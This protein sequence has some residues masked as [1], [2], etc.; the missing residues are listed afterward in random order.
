MPVF[1]VVLLLVFGA[2]WSWQ[3]PGWVRGALTPEEVDYHIGMLEQN[4][5]MPGAEKAELLARLRAWAMADDGKPFFMLNLMRYYPQL[6]RFEGAPAFTGSPL[7]SNEHYETAVAPLALGRGAY[8][9]YAGMTHGQNLVEHA[10]ELD[11]WSRVI[12]M[13][14]PS[15]RAALELFADP[16]YAPVEPFKM[17]ALQVLLLPNHADLVIP[18][19][20]WLLGGVLLFL[21]MA[22]GWWRAARRR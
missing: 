9:L 1:A 11:H 20:R 7:E 5:V 16:D 17:M 4:L 2:F 22:V 3:T 10:A 8:P 12:L 21:F 13:R 14:Y 18:E 15:R 19:L 6:R